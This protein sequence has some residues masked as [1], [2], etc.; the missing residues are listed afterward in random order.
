MGADLDL[1]LKAL[2]KRISYFETMKIEHFALQVED[3]R[4]VVEWYA[5][6]LGFAI[7][8]A[9]EAPT[10]THFLSDSSG[11]VL[12]EFYNNPRVQ[13]PDYASL[14]PLLVHIA[15]VS[16]NPAADRDRLIDA[17]ATI[18]EDLTV[19]PLGDTVIMLRDPWGFAIQLVQRAQRML[20]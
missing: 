15:F 19:T 2:I 5:T 12:V 1:T 6:H 7:K 18:A 17:G 11:A 14:D 8:R 4:A 13:T 9:G 16:E 20:S 3:P 10:Y